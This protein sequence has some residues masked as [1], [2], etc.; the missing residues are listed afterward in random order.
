VL[1]L[2][3]A[4]FAVVLPG[5]VLIW[6]PLWLA[7]FSGGTLAL[8]ALR[9]VGLVPLIIGTAGLLRCIW[10]FGRSGKGT[11]APVDPP[12]FVVRAGLYRVVRNPM[13][14]SVLCALVGEVVLFR[15]LRLAIWGTT[16]A[17]AFHLFV[18]AYEEPTLRRQFGADYETYRRDVPRWLPRR[19]V[20]GGG[21][22]SG[23][24]DA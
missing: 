4:F 9:W 24:V 11:L 17:L 3:S 1:W 21:A 16:V 6:V 22:D 8:G 23:R 15:S 12:R 13:Y 18:V 19:R 14:V 5:T 2:R 10:D 7:T 20:S